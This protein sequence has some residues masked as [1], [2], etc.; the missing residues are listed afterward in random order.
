M[1]IYQTPALTF[2]AEQRAKDGVLCIT[3]AETPSKARTETF[4]AVRRRNENARFEAIT[5]VKT[6]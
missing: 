1:I 3:E 5:G 2:V 4:Q 6:A